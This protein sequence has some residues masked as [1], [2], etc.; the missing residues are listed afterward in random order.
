M[1][2]RPERSPRI[3][4]E[5]DARARG[6]HDLAHRNPRSSAA[7]PR[8]CDRYA[9]SYP[10]QR[11]RQHPPRRHWSARWR[12]SA[13]LQHTHSQ[14]TA[15]AALA[16]H[17]SRAVSVEKAATKPVS[18]RRWR[19]KRRP[20]H[21][22][23]APRPHP[24]SPASLL[25]SRSRWQSKTGEAPHAK[26]GAVSGCGTHSTLRATPLQPPHAR[27]AARPPRAAAKPKPSRGDRQRRGRRAG[28]GAGEGVVGVEDGSIGCDMYPRRS[29]SQRSA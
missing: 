9:C 10:V 28:C 17:V 4:N 18:V 14:N 1:C 16:V 13:P 12:A 5:C 25:A 6:A 24:P 23:D 7:M 26:R 11:L 2:W 22:S 3:A 20:P 15:A 29:T 19:G 8:R 27:S 21:G